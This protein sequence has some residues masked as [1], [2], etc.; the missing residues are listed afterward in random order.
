MS[1]LWVFRGL[2]RG[3]YPMSH[4]QRILGS[5]SE[6]KSSPPLSQHDG[7]SCF[8]H[9]LQ[10]FPC[11]LCRISGWQ[12]ID[13]SARW[14]HKF[15]WDSSVHVRLLYSTYFSCSTR[16]LTSSPFARELNSRFYGKNKQ[17]IEFKMSSF[18]ISWKYVLHA[19]LH[20]LKILIFWSRAVFFLEYKYLHQNILT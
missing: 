9:E 13:G 11:W 5:K 4:F 18:F 12:L 7:G 10:H 8:R 1:F 16:R 19:T 15:W 3:C 14:E 17:N 20:F 6:S 2:T